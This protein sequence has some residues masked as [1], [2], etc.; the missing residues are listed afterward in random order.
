MIFFV[1]VFVVGI[2]LF[3]VS[4]V[5]QNFISILVAIEMLLLAVILISV[6][7][8]LLFDFFEGQTFSIFI[9]SFAAAESALG[10]ALL[11]QFYRAKGRIDYN[12][13]EDLK[14]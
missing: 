11:V 13:S 12:Y 7:F 5:R 9:L 8:S 4:F 14:G 6:S 10:L 3:A 1:G 2:S